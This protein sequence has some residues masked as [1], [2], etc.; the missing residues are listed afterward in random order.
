MYLVPATAGPSHLCVRAAAVLGTV[1][2]WLSLAFQAFCNV[3][4][5]RTRTI[6][7]YNT[8]HMAHGGRWR[9]SATHHW[10]ATESTDDDD[11][12]AIYTRHHGYNNVHIYAHG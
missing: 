8:W 7:R 3:C 12:Y 1:L 5:Q 6:G 10:S 2:S 9:G 11:K 4:M